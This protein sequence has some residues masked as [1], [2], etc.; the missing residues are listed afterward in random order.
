MQGV[1]YFFSIAVLIM[2]V[3]VHEVS[4]GAMANA[5]GDPTARLSGRLSLNPIKHL[6]L[7]GSI[8]LPFLT[9]VSGGFIIGWAKPVPFNPYNLK[10]QR[11]GAA[12]VAL[13]GPGSNILLAVIFGII[14]RFSG[15]IPES[16]IFPF[17]NI[18]ASIIIVNLVLAIFNLVPIP[19]LDGS[20]I[21]FAALPYRYR[22]L[23]DTLEQWGFVLLIF[24]IL[25]IFKYLFPIIE[26]IFRL[27]TGFAL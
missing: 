4:H 17:L 2:S 23:Q 9:L 11:W 21:L 16:L 25:F 7:F 6:D 22:R 18:S 24:F 19:P 12:I 10:N 26:I 5:L 8:I 15:L 3:V 13:A 1:D 27:I 14:I 20:K